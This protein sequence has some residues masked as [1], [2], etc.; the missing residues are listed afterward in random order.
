MTFA[1]K[2]G[3]LSK[4]RGLNLIEVL[5]TLTI[6]SIGL[7]GLVSLQMQSLNATQ[8]SGGYSHAIWLHNDLANRIRANAPGIDAYTNAINC[9]QQP[10]AVC[11]AHHTGSNNVAAINCTPQQLAAWDLRETACGSPR[12]PGIFGSPVMAAANNN[13]TG[14]LPGLQINITCMTAGRCSDG[15]FINMTWRGKENGT[16]LSYGNNILVKP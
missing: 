13:V 10:A 5:V 12:D 6:T 3:L 7:M 16:Q 11:A 2:Q 4:Q 8:D 14:Y 15:V 9:G 1:A